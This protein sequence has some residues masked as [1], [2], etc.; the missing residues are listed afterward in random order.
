MYVLYTISKGLMKVMLS[1]LDSFEM[2]LRIALIGALT[3]NGEEY[4]PIVH[5]SRFVKFSRL[6]KKMIST[7]FWVSSVLPKVID[8]CWVIVH[9]EEMLEGDGMSPRSESKRAGKW[10]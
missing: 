9:C 3:P 4:E 8:E 7:R 2:P 6:S 1:A 5:I 10:K